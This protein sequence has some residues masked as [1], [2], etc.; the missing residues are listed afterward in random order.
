M[1]RA[2]VLAVLTALLASQA[3]ASPDPLPLPA[4]LQRLFKPF[5]KTYAAIEGDAAVIWIDIPMPSEDDLRS[6][7]MLYC[8]P[9]WFKTKNPWGGKKL[10]RLE[11]R[12]RDG[13]AGFAF[14]GGRKECEAVGTLTGDAHEA[15][16]KS[17]TMACLGRNPCRYYRAIK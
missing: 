4:D 9:W 2:L 16:Y 10:K 5:S 6:H 3:I 7:V 14:D 15:F 17:H 11:Y 1:T 12:N 13:S 8:D